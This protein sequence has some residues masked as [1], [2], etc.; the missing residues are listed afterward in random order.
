MTALSAL[1]KSQLELTGGRAI[2]SVFRQPTALRESAAMSEA[3]SVPLRM[4]ASLA[5][6]LVVSA[7]APW[8]QTAPQ[9]YAV[10]ELPN[11]PAAVSPLLSWAMLAF[12]TQLKTA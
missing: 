6:G 11:A 12:V 2:P 8:T 4:S 3:T 10:G 7:N 9:T 5:K 1:A